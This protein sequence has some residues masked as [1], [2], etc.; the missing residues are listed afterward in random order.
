[1]QKYERLN[2]LFPGYVIRVKILNILKLWASSL[3]NGINL[4][5]YRTSLAHHY[6]FCHAET[7]END[8][9]HQIIFSIIKLVQGHGK[10]PPFFM[11]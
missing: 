6:V 7:V 3:C 10:N 8:L 5:N 2:G 1:M 9:G 11:I 4:I